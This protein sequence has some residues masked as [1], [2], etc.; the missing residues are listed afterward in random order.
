MLTL[1]DISAGFLSVTS[2]LL[3]AYGSG[4]SVLLAVTSVHTELE[5]FVRFYWHFEGLSTVILR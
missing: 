2:D 5:K 4:T 1:A 3:G